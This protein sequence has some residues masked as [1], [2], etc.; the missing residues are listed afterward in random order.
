MVVRW[1]SQ[2]WCL[3]PDGVKAAGSCPRCGEALPK[4]K[5][6]HQSRVLSGSLNPLLSLDQELTVVQTESQFWFQTK[7]WSSSPLSCYPSHLQTLIC[8]WLCPD[9][10]H[11]SW[12]ELG[13]FMQLTVRQTCV[14]F[15]KGKR[16][17]MG[18]LSVAHPH[19]GDVL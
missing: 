12:T 6:A 14:V 2:G 9:S 19:R 10:S 16:E 13:S 18:A 7:P 11:R 17:K 3:A 8:P 15:P 1:L 4:A 5:P